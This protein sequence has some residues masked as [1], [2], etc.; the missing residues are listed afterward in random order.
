QRKGWRSPH[1]G[2]PAAVIRPGSA[3]SLLIDAVRFGHKKGPDFSGPQTVAGCFR[4]KSAL[5]TKECQASQGDTEETHRGTT[6]GHGIRGLLRRE[7]VLLNPLAFG[8]YRIR[9][10]RTV[11]QTDV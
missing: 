1:E 4:S 2:N 10:T 3:P 5:A 9:A 8:R 7:G 11:A 6:V